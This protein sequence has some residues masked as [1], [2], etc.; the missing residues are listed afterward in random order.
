MCL[1][2]LPASPFSKQVCILHSTGTYLVKVIRGLHSNGPALLLAF[3]MLSFKL[4]HIPRLAFGTLLSP[5][6]PLPTLALRSSLRPMILFFPDPKMLQRPPVQS[7]DGFR[8][9]AT[10]TPG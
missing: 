8:S 1:L 5:D 2:C 4:G 3:L 9:L 6:F 10:L 7:P